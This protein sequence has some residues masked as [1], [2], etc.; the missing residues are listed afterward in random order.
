[1]DPME[2]GRYELISAGVPDTSVSPWHITSLLVFI[3][4]RHAAIAREVLR[5]GM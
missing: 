2:F 4:S 5:F 3:S 1:M